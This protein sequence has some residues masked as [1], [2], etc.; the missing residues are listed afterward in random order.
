MHFVIV[1]EELDNFALN[2]LEVRRLK[3]LEALEFDFRRVS[4]L[5]NVLES[6]PIRLRK[7]SIYKSL[8]KG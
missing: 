4:R 6:P 2:V 7:V 5:L 3:F 1:E 8:G